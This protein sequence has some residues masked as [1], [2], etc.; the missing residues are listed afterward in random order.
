MHWHGPVKLHYFALLSCDQA[1]HLFRGP[2]SVFGKEESGETIWL[3]HPD[4]AVAQ[5]ADRLGKELALRRVVH[6]DGVMIGKI[7]FQSAESIAGPWRLDEGVL[8]DIHSGPVDCLDIQVAPFKTHLQVTLLQDRRP[9]PLKRWLQV[10]SL[11]KTISARSDGEVR[12]AR[13]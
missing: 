6:I 5:S 10:L 12:L 13:H 7:K 11:P 1:F 8:A 9:A 3:A 2:A 4:A